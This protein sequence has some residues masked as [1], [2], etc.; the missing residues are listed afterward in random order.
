MFVS[1]MYRVILVV[2]VTMVA[3]QNSYDSIETRSV[4]YPG[5]SNSLGSLYSSGLG[6]SQ[7][8]RD[9]SYEDNNVTPT[10]SLA[11]IYRNPGNQVRDVYLK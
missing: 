1:E 7:G 6:S 3:A 2:G 4:A 9:A 8:Y 5:K 11:P 10:P